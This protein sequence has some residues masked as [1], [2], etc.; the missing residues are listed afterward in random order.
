LYRLSRRRGTS[1][2]TRGPGG[3][4]SAKSPQGGP[5]PRT[6]VPM[7]LLCPRVT[8]PRLSRSDS[9]APMPILLWASP[10]VGFRR[11]RWGRPHCTRPGAPRVLV[12]V[13]AQPPKPRSS[14]ARRVLL[15]ESPSSQVPKGPVPLSPITAR[16]LPLKTDCVHLKRYFKRQKKKEGTHCEI[17]KLPGSVGRLKP[18]PNGPPVVVGSCSDSTGSVSAGPG[19]LRKCLGD[20]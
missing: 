12:A 1:K 8:C 13:D 18:I 10:S 6:G 14:R 5:H 2:G 7:Q 4:A 20:F 17:I 9:V 16:G 3:G 11:V 19:S 15:S